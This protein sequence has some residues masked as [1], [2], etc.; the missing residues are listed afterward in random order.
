MVQVTSGLPV[1]RYLELRS[2]SDFGQFRFVQF[3][4]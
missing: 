2:L 1:T 3:G 4:C